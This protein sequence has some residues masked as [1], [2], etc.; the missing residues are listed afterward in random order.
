ML[1]YA[2]ADLHGRP[3]RLAAMQTHVAEHQPDVLILAGDLSR[4]M[5]PHVL[6]EPL[7]RLQPPVFFIRGNSDSRRLG[8]LLGRPSTLQHLH[9]K[10]KTVNGVGFVGIGGALPLPFHSRLGWTE[11]DRVAHLCD[12]LQPGDILVAH[13]PPYG[14]RDRVLGR[15]HAGSRAVERIVER[16]S[17]AITICGHIH[18][19][20]GMEALGETLVVNCAM[21]RSCGG[22][23]IRYDGR[24]VPACTMLA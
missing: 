24:S 8:A 22:A 17:P 4:R 5:R 21:S 14:A 15:F 16:C 3:E 19:Q 6:I 10:R 7:G 20:A 2:V 9:L 13:P 11:G 23:L 1:I 18:E 12:L